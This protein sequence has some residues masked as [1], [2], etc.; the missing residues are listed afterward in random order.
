M[1][2]PSS[3]S[4]RLPVLKK[5][6]KHH[7]FRDKEE[8]SKSLEKTKE[9]IE[10]NNGG[11][12]QELMSSNPIASDNIENIYENEIKRMSMIARQSILEKS[13]LKESKKEEIV[14]VSFSK[15]NKSLRFSRYSPRKEEKTCITLN[16]PYLA[17][18]RTR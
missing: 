7:R 17:T 8:L 12:S 1:R 18:E 15:H 16:I 14:N 3:P 2:F 10:N 5:T 13:K 11:S 6:V 4:V 9:H